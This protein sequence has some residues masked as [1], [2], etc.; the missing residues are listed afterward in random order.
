[1]WKCGARFRWSI[2]LFILCLTVADCGF[3]QTRSYRNNNKSNGGPPELEQKKWEPSNWKTIL[4]VVA[5]VLFA[6]AIIYGSN[7][8]Y[9]C[10]L[11]MCGQSEKK[12]S[13]M[14]SCTNV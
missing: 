8:F 4:I 1:M 3:K 2:L 14:D 5:S 6:F 7:C 9:V 11:Y 12:Y 10:K 13:K